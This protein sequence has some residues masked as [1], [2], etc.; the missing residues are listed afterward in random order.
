MR[1]FTFG[2]Y[3]LLNGGFDDGR[4]DRLRHQLTL[5]ADLGADTWAFQECSGWRAAGCRAL[6]TAERILGLRGF[7]CRRPIT[8]MISPY[9]CVSL[10]GCALW[11]SDT[12]RAT[13]TGMLSLVSWLRRRGPGA[14]STLLAHTLRRHPRPFAWRKPRPSR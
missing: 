6:F 9:S 5:L 10:Q 11:L 12:R 8:A 1:E 14:C 4:D 13:R 3:N 2:S 7:S